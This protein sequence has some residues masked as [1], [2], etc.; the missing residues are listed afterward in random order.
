[1][2]SFDIFGIVHHTPGVQHSLEEHSTQHFICQCIGIFK[3][4]SIRETFLVGFCCYKPCRRKTQKPSIYDYYFSGKQKRKSPLG[5]AWYDI[6]IFSLMIFKIC[7]FQVLASIR[8]KLAK[9][10][11]PHLSFNSSPSSSRTEPSLRRCQLCQGWHIFTKSSIKVLFWEAFFQKSTRKELKSHACM[12]TV[13]G[14]KKEWRI[15]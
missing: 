3:D 10:A 15:A 6:S 14:K 7:K 5:Y 13:P 1:M 11:L 12:Y 8:W 4:P 2:E 9:C